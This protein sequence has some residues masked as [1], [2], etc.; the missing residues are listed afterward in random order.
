MNAIEELVNEHEAIRL[1]LK[2][3][4]RICNEID[5]SR[6]IPNPADLE[7]LLEFFGVFVD[8]CH[9]SK[10]EDLLFPALEAVGISRTGGPIG[11]LL[12]E[13]EQGRQHVARMKRGLS[14]YRNGD[15]RALST[16]NNEARAYIDLLSRHIQKENQVL[17]PL[18][19]RHLS[20]AAQN[21]LKSGFD[22]IEET[23]IGAGR[24]EA[25]HRLLDRLE[26]DY[27]TA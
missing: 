1:T 6:S 19:A 7:Q 24:H 21:E 8:R 18:A 11:V 5:H 3:L 20:A 22:R 23:K 26:A 12:E 13:H 10:E 16:V 25:F 27:L 9:Q 17:F 4:D 15:P 14:D 2:I